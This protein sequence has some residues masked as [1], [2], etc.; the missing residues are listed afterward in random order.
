M[1][2]SFIGPAFM[3]CR[4]CTRCHT[5]LKSCATASFVVKPDIEAE[6]A[7]CIQ[8]SQ[9]PSFVNTSKGAP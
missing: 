4:D 1:N 3:A 2:P 6:V 9:E 8:S 5:T 7:Q